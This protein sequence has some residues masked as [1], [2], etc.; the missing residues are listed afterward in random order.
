MWM[1]II[2]FDEVY[3]VYFKTNPKAITDYPNLF[4]WC[5]D[6]WKVPGI[7]E[8]TNMNH[9]KLHYYTSHASLNY[10]A[11]VPKGPNFIGKMED[12][13]KSSQ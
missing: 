10:Y 9:I 13:I 2:R 11:I 8:T 4:R 1:T 3:V 5:C 12:A 6:M 7:K